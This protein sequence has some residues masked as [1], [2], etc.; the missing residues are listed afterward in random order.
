M[1]LSTIQKV[2]YW[3]VKDGNS[4][5]KITNRRNV[6]MFPGHW[7]AGVDYTPPTAEE[8]D[9]NEDLD[10]NYRAQEYTGDDELD[11]EEMYDR[12]DQ[13]EIDQLANDSDTTP[14][15]TTMNWRRQR[16]CRSA[17]QQRFW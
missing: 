4:N 12:I 16:K 10:Y 17:R 1:T 7:S 6:D 14:E 2:E 3:A 5:Y 8:I 15:T 9:D 13:E 11:D